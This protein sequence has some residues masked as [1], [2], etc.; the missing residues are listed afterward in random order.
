MLSKRRVSLIAILLTQFFCG[1]AIADS[2]SFDRAVAVYLKGF[3][4]CVNANTLRS[5]DIHAAKKKLKL[6]T[7]YLDDAVTIDSSILISKERQM[8]ENLKYC[9]KA[10]DNILRAE[11]TPI[12]DKAFIHCDE[13]EAAL[14]R[15]D[16]DT[17][18]NSMAAYEDL[19]KKALASTDKILDTY[20]IA[21]NVR[22]CS[23]LAE[24]LNE[25]KVQIAQ[26]NQSIQ[27]SLD[28]AK[29]TSIECSALTGKT[30]QP[31]FNFDN[32][33]TAQKSLMQIKTTMNQ[34]ESDASTA[35]TTKEMSNSE[36]AQT[37]NLLRSQIDSCIAQ[38]SKTINELDSKRNAILQEIENTKGQIVKANAA[39]NSAKQLLNSQEFNFSQLNKIEQLHKQ[40]KTLNNAAIKSSGYQRARQQPSWPESKKVITNTNSSNQCVKQVAVELQKKQDAYA[41]LKKSQSDQLQTAKRQEKK[42]TVQKVD[43]PDSAQQTVKPQKTENVKQAKTEKGGFKRGSW[44]GLANEEDNQVASRDTVAEVEG[45]NKNKED[46]NDS[47]EAWMSK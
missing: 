31:G 19:K 38:N 13:A 25:K 3:E 26:L 6:Y 39:C 32:I 12:I 27:K 29:Q 9:E 11:A 14:N 23:R 2:E 8:Q 18:A 46:V 42:S 30:S 20:A 5:S 37:F 7:Q 22:Q 35:L 43:Q 4:E 10:N 34:L 24:K 16:L 21:S 47:W 15:G 17:S 33:D 28:Q 44:M 40:S 41:D 36:E 1:Q 45:K